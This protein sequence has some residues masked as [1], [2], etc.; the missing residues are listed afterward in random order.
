MD[1]NAKTETKQLLTVT[2][3]DS[4]KT[5]NSRCVSAA[6]AS[7]CGCG[8]GVCFAG[9]DSTQALVDRRECRVCGMKMK[10]GLRAEEEAQAV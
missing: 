4:D 9:D 10:G 6:S 8:E 5:V 3:T 7:A 2:R 1:V